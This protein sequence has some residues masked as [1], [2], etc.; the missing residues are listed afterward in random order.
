M[1]KILGEL[2]TDLKEKSEEIEQIRESKRMFANRAEE[3]DFI[4]SNIDDIVEAHI[5]GVVT[6]KGWDTRAGKAL[7]EKAV[8]TNTGVSVPTQSIE[9]FETEVSTQLERDIE[10]ELVLDPMFRKIQ[11]SAASMVIP[12]FPDAGYAEFL[13]TGSTAGSGDTGPWNG[14]LE[15]RGDAFGSPYDGI[16]MGS[17]VLT[18]EKVVSK[19]YLANEVEED[20]IMPVLPL[21]RE[22]MVR[23]H[24]RTVEHS[25]LMGGHSLATVTGGYDGLVEMARDDSK[26]LDIGSPGTSTQVTAE[27]LL[28]LRQAMGKYGRRPGD[29][30]YIIS[31]D[32]Y[33]DLLDDADF[34]SVNEIGS[35]RATRIHGEIAQVFGSPVVVCDEFPA[36]A[37]GSP[38]ALALNT[39]HFLVP[40]LRGTTVEQ[41]YDVENQRRV[42]VATQR[43]GFDRMFSTA[44]QV[45]AHTY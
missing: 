6:R 34:Q 26:T 35:E 5:L 38:F 33:Y 40:V 39:R 13:A 4:K 9:A 20:A 11:M 22:S 3:G 29:V 31:L 45:V 16:Q 27:I 1:E 7:L 18:V 10:L 15:T 2:Q 30:V 37:N 41:D 14:N 21:I 17:K 12:T 44:G 43:R 23:S 24:S 42:L 28:N 25:Q 32:A 8:N 19:S 36:K